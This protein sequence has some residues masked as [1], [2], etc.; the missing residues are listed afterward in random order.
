MIYDKVAYQKL[1]ENKN[2]DL[3]IFT[4]RHHVSSKNNPEMYGWVKI[5]NNDNA[6]G[7]SV[8]S[9]ISDNPYED[10]AIVGTFY[11]RKVAY[12]NKALKSL[13]EK[14]IKVNGEYYV[15]SLIG[16][17]IE[18]GLKVKIFEIQDYICWGKPDDYETFFYWQSFFSKVSW[19]P[20]SL[21]K[22]FTVNREKINEL[23]KIYK[24]FYQDF[25]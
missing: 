21:K 3:V 2:V 12:F 20:Y 24:S 11:F 13:L 1:I 5:D 14:D 4:F 6:L 23:K 8:K 16:E 7:V 10:H 9:A 17:A 22:D 15:D 25:I 19:H 18:L